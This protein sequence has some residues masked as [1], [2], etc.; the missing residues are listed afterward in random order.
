[1]NRLST[2]RQT[3]RTQL[4]L[5]LLFLGALPSSALAQRTGATPP[6]TAPTM[7]SPALV[8]PP[9]L[10][11]KQILAQDSRLDRPVSLDVISVPLN[12]V[13]Q[14]E[15]LD[16]ST[17]TMEDGHRFLLTAAPDC[18][19]L[20]MQVRLNARPLRTLMTA[21]AEML[22]GTWTRTPTAISFP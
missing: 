17:D 15:S 16:K 14:K 10:S 18:A 7:P 3:H 12:E 20:K 1:M 4:V 2:H 21:L 11:Q 9:A 8:P 19:D 5:F 6:V 13:L 22:P